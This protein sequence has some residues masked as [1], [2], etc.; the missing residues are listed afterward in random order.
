MSK[1]ARSEGNRVAMAIKINNSECYVADV[2]LGDEIEDVN[3]A[4]ESVVKTLGKVKSNFM[5][6]S[7]DVKYLI[8]TVQMFDASKLNAKDWLTASLSG[9]SETLV[10]E[11]LISENDLSAKIA[12]EL[13][14]PFK[15]KDVIR[16]NAFSHLRH[17][18]L[19]QEESEEE[20]Y[21]DI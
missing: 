14:T 13:D 10:K 4:S 16:S 19:L 18:N 5:L 6:I 21:F 17:L 8:V 20:E 12:L 15:Y 2:D 11:K 3:V 1:K 7:A 9:I